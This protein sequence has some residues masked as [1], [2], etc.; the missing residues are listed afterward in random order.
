MTK[1]EGQHS[2]SVRRIREWTLQNWWVCWGSPQL[3]SGVVGDL[4]LLLHY[5]RSIQYCS[6]NTI[7]LKQWVKFVRLFFEGYMC[8]K[9]PEVF[10]LLIKSFSLDTFEYSGNVEFDSG[11]CWWYQVWSQT[12]MILVWVKGAGG[13]PYWSDHIDHIGYCDFL[14]RK[15]SLNLWYLSG[16]CNDEELQ[17]VLNPNCY[18]LIA[19][20]EYG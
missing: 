8:Q 3:L 12:Q 1:G 14:P 6:F 16:Y 18:Y 17:L 9:I 5:N 15:E 19:P 7:I 2:A 4:E 13:C 10:W 20:L 11:S